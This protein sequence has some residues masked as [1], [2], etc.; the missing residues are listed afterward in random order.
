MS[1]FQSRRKAATDYSPR[2]TPSANDYNFFESAKSQLRNEAFLFNDFLKVLNLYNEDILTRVDL[3][4]M[5][6]DLFSEYPELYEEFRQ[7][8]DFSDITSLPETRRRRSPSPSPPRIDSRCE[9]DIST[10]KHYGP[11]Y[12]GL[13]DEYIRPKCSGRNELCDEVLNDHWFSVPTGSEEG[14]KAS[15]KNQ[16]EENL[17]ACEDKRHEL[18]LVIELNNSTIQALIPIVKQLASCDE[19]ELTDFRIEDGLDILMLRSIERIYGNK[20]HAIIQGINE[21]PVVAI[22]I[23]LRRLQQKNVEWQTSKSSWNAIWQELQEKNYY[24]SLDHQS[25][26]FKLKEKKFLNPR[27]LLA[28]IKDDYFENSNNTPSSSSSTPTVISLPTVLTFEMKETAIFQ[29]IEGLIEF[30][31]ER[32][33]NSETEPEKLKNFIQGFIRKFFVNPPEDPSSE[34]PVG[35]FFGNNSFYVFFRFYQMLFERLLDAKKMAQD[36]FDNPAPVNAT[37]AMMSSKLTTKPKRTFDTVEAKYEFYL[38]KMLRPLVEGDMDSSKYEDLCRELF[39]ISS[40]VLFT[41]DR[42]LQVLVKQVRFL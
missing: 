34:Q 37:K 32:M 3:L 19:D 35:L 21:N 6:R 41:M 27:E 5:T 11:S 18:D 29:D 4:V 1:F 23:V 7:F 10:C 15:L 42:L 39:G 20:G 36:S 38:N 12:R 16:Y 9:I 26:H 33:Y 31:A 28:E 40:Y 8:C 25:A 24:R 14:F 17:F 30:Q 2:H 13:P 22:P